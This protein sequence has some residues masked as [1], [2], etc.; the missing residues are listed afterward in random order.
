MEKRKDYYNKLLDI[1]LMT[2]L[3]DGIWSGGA[4]SLCLCILIKYV[5]YQAA[6]EQLRTVSSGLCTDQHRMMA[7][8]ST[9]I[10]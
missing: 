1:W 2:N 4:K 8:V 9:N 3:I 6:A 7:A 10:V 5:F